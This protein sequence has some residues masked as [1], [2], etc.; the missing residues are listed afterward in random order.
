[1][2][3]L[4]KEDYRG[5]KFVDLVGGAREQ[6]RTSCKYCPKY[7]GLGLKILLHTTPLINWV[8]PLYSTERSLKGLVSG[9]L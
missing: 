6:A 2:F 7:P 1:M 9:L 5:W 8:I 3:Y 4:L